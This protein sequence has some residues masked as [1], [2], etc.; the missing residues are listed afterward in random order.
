MNKGNI[1]V[2]DDT[3][4]NLVLLEEI[5]YDAGYEVRTSTSGEMAIRSIEAQIPDLILLDVMMND[6]DGYETCVQI[7]SN[8]ASKD[9]PVIFVSAKGEAADKVKGFEAGGIDYLTKPFDIDE[10][11]ARI[12]THLT[13][14]FLQKTLKSKMDIIDKHV[15]TSSL[16]VDKIITEVSEAYCQTV[17]YTKEELIGKPYSVLMDDN[18]LLYNEI[19]QKIEKDHIWKGE[20]ESRRKDGASYWIDAIISSKTDEEG[21]IIGYTCIGH[22]ITDKKMI[23]ELSI[24][25]QLTDLYNRRHFNNVFSTEIQRSSRQLSFLSF[26]MMDVDYFKLYNDTYGHQ[27]GDNVL[28][29]IGT[30]LKK[31]MR[32]YGD[33]AFRLGGEEFGMLFSVNGYDH[34]KAIAENVREEIENL[35]IEH[36]SSEVST[37]VTASLG[38]VSVDFSNKINIHYTIEDLYKI[39][40]DELYKAKKEG[41]NRISTIFI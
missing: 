14:H 26:I 38:L 17:G 36:R 4:T 24:T 20:I 23:E 16:N 10:I 18:E 13:L 27:K 40:D 15:I 7:K 39:A 41:R 19:C 30:V 34:A 32:R 11:L 6:M 25:D 3:P 12:N 21:E 2:V 31:C 37:V 1:L 33:F 28:I 29:A 35:N 8:K 5:L 22:D 9:I